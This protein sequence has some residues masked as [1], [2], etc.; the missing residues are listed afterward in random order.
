MIWK[1]EYQVIVSLGNKPATISTIE[2]EEKVNN[3]IKKGWIPVGGIVQELCKASWKDDS[4]LTYDYSQ[5][6]VK[7]EFILM[8]WL[9]KL[10]IRIAQ[11]VKPIPQ[12]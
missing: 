6:M 3:Q 12:V 9:N 10:F 4:P 2:L 7:K 11:I 5:A 8:Y 1:Y